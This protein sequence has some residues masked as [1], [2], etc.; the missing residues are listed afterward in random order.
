[1]TQPQNDP[2]TIDPDSVTP[3]RQT[4]HL[5]HAWMEDCDQWEGWAM[6][7]NLRTA[8]EIAAAA[9]ADDEY[10]FRN[11]AEE[12]GAA[13]GVLVWTHAHHSWHLIDGGRDTRIRIT[14]TAIYGRAPSKQDAQ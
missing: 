4:G 8:M 3:A 10:P 12:P 9:Y 13:P 14:P 2:V 1:V 6:Y 7:T 11:D 5:F